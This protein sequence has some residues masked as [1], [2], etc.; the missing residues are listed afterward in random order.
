MLQL[1]TS[2]VEIR[3]NIKKLISNTDFIIA[4]SRA[5]ST[6]NVP[7]VAKYRKMVASDL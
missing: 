6:H 7:F 1:E 4:L 2:T 3:E 5:S